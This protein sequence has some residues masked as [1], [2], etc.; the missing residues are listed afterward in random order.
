MRLPFA[1]FA[2]LF[3]AGASAAGVK[4]PSGKVDAAT[5]VGRA[6]TDRGA[7]QTAVRIADEVG[8][9]LAGSAK[10]AQAVTWAVAEMKARGLTNV[11]TEPV[12]VDSWQR[13]ADDR[14]ELVAPYAH[15]LHALAL[16][17]SVGTPEA[18]ITADV[19]EV[20]SLD[21]LKK[22]DAHGKIVFFDPIM[23]R[24]RTFDE[25][26]RVGVMRF[27]G[28]VEAGRAGAVAVVIR[29]VG[30]GLHRLPHTG[31]TTY[32]PAVAPIPFAA[33]AAEDAMLLHRALE[34]GPARLSLHLSCGP[35][36]KVASAN[37]V[38]DVRGRD[39]AN[40][41]VLLGAHLDS[42]DVG[43]G[44]IDDGAGI[45]I[46]LEAAHLAVALKPRRT[47]RVV[48]FMNEEYGLSGAKAYATAHQAE[49]SHHVV[50]IE[51]DAGAGAP[52]GFG[53]SGGEP[54]RA[55]LA[56]LIQPLVALTGGNILL[57]EHAGADISTLHDAGVPEVSVR[58]DVSDYFEWHHTDGD[59]ADKIDPDAISRAAAAYAVLA[60]DLAEL[61][62]KLPRDVAK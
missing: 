27:H 26:G 37:V 18:G 10:A 4:A 19:V 13:G 29:S 40:E 42:W 62:E 58:Q 32:D 23:Q 8:A 57:T 28:A 34:K 61:D 33:L 49:L 35:H 9:R 3:A 31:A 44:A 24:S 11:H 59:T 45:G 50:A 56:R 48:L 53:V 12:T 41:I 30:T 1:L 21:A 16:G 15:R 36:G 25:Y 60:I 51:A 14:V 17:R 39:L 52:I 43:D 46:V 47:I 2:A 5:I 6:L 54:A 38:G 22:I 20:D 7:Y 55:I